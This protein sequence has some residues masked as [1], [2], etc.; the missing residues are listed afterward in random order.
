MRS[1]H[2]GPKF[3]QRS[4]YNYRSVALDKVLQIQI[5]E[6]VRNYAASAY[7]P[8]GTCMMGSTNNNNVVVNARDMSVLGVD[9]LKVWSALCLLQQL[10]LTI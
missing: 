9:N 8:C 10:L 3:N 1:D 6:F 5:D 2:K 4:I 7:H